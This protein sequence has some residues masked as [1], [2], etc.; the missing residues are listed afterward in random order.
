MR[1]PPEVKPEAQNFQG[2]I[3]WSK[4]LKM[5][6]IPE[7]RRWILSVH[8]H[9]SDETGLTSMELLQ[10][11]PCLWEVWLFAP[12]QPPRKVDEVSHPLALGRLDG[13]EG[14]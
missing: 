12:G 1:T 3:V 2:G 8:Q 7:Y 4:K 14:A 13:T 5:R 6:V 11:K 9:I 10:V